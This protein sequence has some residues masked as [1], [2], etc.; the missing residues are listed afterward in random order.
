VRIGHLFDWAKEGHILDPPSN[1]SRPSRDS[2]NGI[3]TEQPAPIE[4]RI[5]DE[6]QFGKQPLSVVW[7]DI[8]KE[9][10]TQIAYEKRARKYIKMVLGVVVVGIAAVV[11]GWRIK[12]QPSPPSKRVEW[13]VCYS[14]TNR[15][16][17]AQTFAD[18]V[19]SRQAG[20]ARPTELKA[21]TQ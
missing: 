16:Q 2:K 18:C 4:F 10:F 7:K 1:D 11:V 20:D 19:L 8:A 9:T 15:N 13:R 17:M 6:P 3:K 5:C 14:T 21:Q 12:T